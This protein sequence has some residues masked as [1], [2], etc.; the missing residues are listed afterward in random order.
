MKAKELAEQL[1]KNPDL[2]VMF[3]DPNSNGGPF[4]VERVTL[5][6]AEEDEFPED[7]NMPKGY[8]FLELN[9]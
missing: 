3:V 7:F 6:E 8:K 9:N 5:K 1:L 4:S 2:N